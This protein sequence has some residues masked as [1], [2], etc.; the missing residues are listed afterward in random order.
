MT[1]FYGLVTGA[2]LAA[3]F[4]AFLATFLAAFLAM[5]SLLGSSLPLR[6]W[7]FA[8]L[9]FIPSQLCTWEGLAASQ[10]VDE[11]LDEEIPRPRGCED[12]T[13]YQPKTVNACDS[14]AGEPPEYCE[15]YCKFVFHI[16]TVI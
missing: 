16:C 4:A 8:A 9:K 11:F 5:V 10:Q 1:A 3:F 15:Q 2:F 7:A 12:C 6:V 14:D 13:D